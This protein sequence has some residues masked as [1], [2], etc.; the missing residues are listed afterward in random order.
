MGS[1]FKLFK[2]RGILNYPLDLFKSMLRL[3]GRQMVH[4][5]MVMVSIMEEQLDSTVC[6]ENYIDCI[7]MAGDKLEYQQ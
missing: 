5:Y 4:V 6:S 1:G 3:G 2:L 7:D